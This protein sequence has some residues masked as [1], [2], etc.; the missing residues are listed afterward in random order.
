ML[1]I[2]QQNV[3]S[4]LSRVFSVHPPLTGALLRVHSSMAASEPT[5]LLSEERHLLIHSEAIEGH[6]GCV[7]AV[8]LLT[9]GTWLPPSNESKAFL[10]EVLH[11][12]STLGRL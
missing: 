6:Y 10:G 8:S 4:I 5:T 2:L 12:L 11:S 1:I 9:D 7:W 3:R